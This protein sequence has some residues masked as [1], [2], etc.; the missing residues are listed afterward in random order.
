[1]SSPEAYGRFRRLPLATLIAVHLPFLFVYFRSL[2]V[3]THYQFFP[4]A[5]ASFVWL[6]ASRRSHE[7]EKWTWTAKSLIGVDVVC[8]AAGIFFYSPWLFAVGLLATLTAWCLA[9]REIGYHRNL[10]YL[11]ILPLLVIRLPLNFDEQ[12]IHGLQRVTTTIASKT[13]HRAS[14][15]HYREGNILQ[16]PGKRFLVEEACS[17]VQ[18]VFTILFLAAMVICLKRRSMIHGTFLLAIGVIIAGIMNTLRVLTIAVAWESYGAD[19][20]TGL[21]HDA[22]GYIC[23]A[24]AAAFLMS[25]DAFLG[26]LSDAVPDARRPGAVGLFFNPLISLWNQIVSVIPA[27]STRAARRDLKP[28]GLLQNNATLSD[29]ERRE[30]PQISDLI[31]P[32]NWLYFGL[33]WLESWVYSRKYRQLTTGSP[34]ALLTVSSI[35]IVW[36]LKHAQVDP[37]IAQLENTFNKAVASNDTQ[38]QETALHALGS[39]R[40]M[41]PQYRFRLAQ[42]MTQHGRVNEGLN[43]I[44]ALTPAAAL[45]YA[46][47]RM[48]L[49][50]Q[51]LQRSPFMKLSVDDIEQQLRAVLDQHPTHIEAHKLLAQLYADRM[52]WKLAE[53]HLSEAAKAQPENN[54]A[55]AK[56]MQRLARSKESVQV[57]AQRAVD[58]YTAKLENDRADAVTRISLAESSLVAGR[59]AEAREILVSG[60]QQEDDPL[61]RKALSDF[62]LMVTDRRL[63]ESSLNR[64]ASLSVVL[65][66][67]QRDP[68]N[69]T[70]VLLLSKLKD[71]GVQVSAGSLSASI[72]HWEDAVEQQADAVSARVLLSQLLET[73]DQFARAAEMLE[74]AVN[75]H[76]EMRL[77]LAKLLW[78]SGRIE[79][80]NKILAVL[81]SEAQA[82]LKETPADLAANIQLCEAMIVANDPESARNHLATLSQNPT[83]SRIP[84][85]SELAAL[86]GRACVLQFDKLAGYSPIPESTSANA[87]FNPRATIEPE[88]LLDL[89][90]DAIQCP[91]TTNQAIDR[92]SRLSLSMHA[93]AAD[94]ERILRQLRL[95][96]THGS[97]VLNLLGMHALLMNRFDKAKPWLEQANL[98]T[99]G[100]DPMILNNLA[101]AIIRSGENSQERALS[102][103]NETLALIPNHPDALSTR[104]EVYVAMGRW[105][106]AIADLT[107]SLTMRQNNSELHRLLEKAY[108]GIQDSQMAEE[109][110]RRA[111][112]LEASRVPAG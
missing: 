68:S 19:W 74:P 69:V 107:Q 102:L 54:L 41:E 111:E 87:F 49:V 103:A 84:A 75:S 17:G 43:E 88:V 85:A 27:S 7:G 20:S 15:L 38:S 1:M 30:H 25:A 64:D 57:V 39:L 83:K 60:L 21:S 2:W 31:K 23:L 37:I 10:T 22:L 94:A 6:F 62:D 42:F 91:N 78:R 26:F 48:W 80:A 61:L 99:R 33:G 5:I 44:L 46:D 56:L 76:P 4:F 86:Y 18:S 66:A 104:G 82:K 35:L 28:E 40:P 36:W 98:Q 89:L 52:E 29:V 14:V 105:P 58:A 59:E 9:N 73:T 79:D 95:E 93:A 65:Q 34:F 112:T 24:V 101:T 8:L 3:H 53:Q 77:S 97:Q 71:M 110:R 63:S 96:G 67:L 16:F 92:L 51:S 109:H 70:A 45:G 12:V 90:A 47:A 55:L 13:L 72:L 81:T 106:E 100:R 32:A 50:K 108:T 11:A